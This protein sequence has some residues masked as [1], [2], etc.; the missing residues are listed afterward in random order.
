MMAGWETTA[1]AA[2]QEGNAWLEPQLK[3]FAEIAVPQSRTPRREYLE[4]A[5]SRRCGQRNIS[6][7]IIPASPK[8]RPMARV[9]TSTMAPMMMAMTI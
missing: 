4:S 9:T 1:A 3:T 5:L 2:I 6:C 7:I 8:I